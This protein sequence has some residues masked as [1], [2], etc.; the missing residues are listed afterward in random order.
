MFMQLKRKLSNT[1]PA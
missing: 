1:F